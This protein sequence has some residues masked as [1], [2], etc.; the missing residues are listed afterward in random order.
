MRIALFSDTYLPTVNGVA[1][2]LGLL[3]EHARA[4]GHEVAL[5]TP[6]V[7]EGL[8][9]EDVAF[10][11]TLPGVPAPMYPELQAARPWLGR[12][13]R[14]RL[15]RF[16]PH[17]AHVATEAGV[18]LAGRSWALS[19]RIPLLT[20]FNTH[21]PDY[22]AGYGL[23]RLEGTLWAYLRWFHGRA[24]ARVCPSEWARAEMLQHGIKPPV[25]IWSRGVDSRAFH[26][27]RRS[28]ALR[29]ELAP[30]ADVL[31]MYVGRIAPEKRVPLL[32]EAWPEIRT[33]A[34][35][36]V[37]LVLVGDGPALEELQ[38]RRLEGVV[39]T[40]YR[41]GAALGAHFASGDVFVFPSDTETFGQVVTEA[42]A[43]GLPA[44]A[45]RR[46]GVVDTVVPGR[47][48]EL[49][50]PGDAGDLARKTLLLIE[51]DVLRRRMARAARAEAEERSWSR[52]F[53]SLFTLYAETCRDR[54]LLVTDPH[55]AGRSG[56]PRFQAE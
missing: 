42:L 33:R 30:D 3:V 38:G 51:D 6:K 10:H 49:F 50:E 25:G 26:P 39:F 22:L 41:H 1:R 46:G 54:G 34:S 27:R 48:G 18:G 16:D 52:V 28:E 55:P 32:L 35:R 45:P 37:V 11:E 14:R 4:A 40:G 44:I 2:A 9:A 36:K 21:F 17:I 19:R 56:S 5:V 7:A 15:E 47:T 29:R 43:S 8:P 12:R 31:L 13:I 20:S 53:R 23:G 24:D